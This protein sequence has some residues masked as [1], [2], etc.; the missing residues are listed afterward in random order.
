MFYDDLQLSEIVATRMS[1]DLIGNMGALS[2]AL[3]LI[4][5]NDDALDECSLSILKTATFTLNAR[6][7]FFR[8]A[9]GVDSKKIEMATLKK[10][11]DDYLQTCTNRTDSFSLSFNGVRPEMAKFVCL[12]VMT[13]AEVC[14]RG[15][16]IEIC[17]NKDNMIISVSSA[18]NLSAVKIAIYEDVLKGAEIKDDVPQYAHLIYLRKLLGNEIKMQLISDE[19]NMK[20]VIG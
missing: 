13:A 14:I 11:C 16:N 8:L 4:A 18:Y 12:G 3:E 20:I 5:D 2:N 7:K 19:K 10:I 9:F 6:Q 15:G 1:H 17:I